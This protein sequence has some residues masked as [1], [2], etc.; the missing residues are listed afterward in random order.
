[1]KLVLLDRSI[2]LTRQEAAEQGERE[3]EEIPL[4]QF[5]TRSED[6]VVLVGDFIENGESAAGE[7][8]DF[9]ADPSRKSPSERKTVL[10][11]LPRPFDLKL[12]HPKELGC[13]P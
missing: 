5:G 12:H 4:A 3:F 8:F 2:T 11:V 6:A 13:F 10:E 9:E 1:M 7:E